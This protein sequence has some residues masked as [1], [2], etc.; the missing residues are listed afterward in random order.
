MI[1]LQLIQIFQL[2]TQAFSLLDTFYTSP[3]CIHYTLL[4]FTE[5][6]RVNTL[7]NQVLT[8]MYIVH[9]LNN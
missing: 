8:F 2:S 4:S 1:K 3:Q 5:L 9:Q 6:K 7:L